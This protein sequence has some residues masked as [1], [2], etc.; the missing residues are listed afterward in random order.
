MGGDCGCVWC[1]WCASENM[2][3]AEGGL[4]V[5]EAMKS[6]KQLTSVDLWGMCMV[7]VLCLCCVVRCVRLVRVLVQLWPVVTV[8]GGGC[9]CVR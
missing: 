5:A 2:L 7:C 3:G 9:C 4:A 6:C 8:F 1:V